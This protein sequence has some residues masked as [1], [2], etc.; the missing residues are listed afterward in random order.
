M[1]S[2]RVLLTGGNGL[3]GR[4]LRRLQPQMH[5]NWTLVAPSRAEYD[6]VD[7][8][9]VR[10][11]FA[12][13]PFDLVIHA[14]ARV[15]GIAA[16]VSHP[17]GFL[18]DNLIINALTIEGARSAGVKRM[19]YLGSSC[20]Y[21]KDMPRAMVE[22]DLLTAPLEPTNEGYA[23][24]KIAGA[25]QCEAIARE[26]GLSYRTII[27]CNLY[28]PDDHFGSAASHLVAAALTKL[29]AARTRG[30]ETVSIWGAGTARREFLYV[31]DLSSFILDAADRIEDLPLYLNVGAQLDYTVNEYYESA[32]EVVG[33][34][35]SFVH[36][37][38]APVGMLR[39]LLDSSRAAA[40]GWKPRTT[41]LEGL[42]KSYLGLIAQEE[43]AAL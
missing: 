6:L 32:A 35:G 29:H 25:K 20:M 43:N 17:V 22:E 30:E 18:A 28:G 11:L 7:Q 34:K 38:S 23:I 37:L 15:G 10:R 42:R 14:A 40:F 19:L 13:G 33:F 21:P 5:P 9:A 41:L 4:S 8:Q 1:T 27:P 36:D 39:K 16:N 31:D 24:A 2:M 12:S 3:V 26:H